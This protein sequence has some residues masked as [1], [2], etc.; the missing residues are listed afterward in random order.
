MNKNRIEAFTDGGYANIITIMVLE[1]KVSHNRTPGSY[2][3][4]W[5]VFISYAVSFLFVEL[6]W[7]VIITYFKP[8]L[9][10]TIKCFG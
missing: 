5:P 4:M 2:V 3:Q 10:L 6:N 1:L 8:F 9:K 7:Q